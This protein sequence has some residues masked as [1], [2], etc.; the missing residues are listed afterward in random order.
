MKKILL[1]FL[2]ILTNGLFGEGFS[3]GTLVC[4]TDKPVFVEELK[5]GDEL[6]C[7]DF[8]TGFS[9]D[10]IKNIFKSLEEKVVCIK[11]GEEEVACSAK[12]RFLD[13]ELFEWVR[14][15]DLTSQNCLLTVD[16]KVCAVRSVEPVSKKLELFKISMERHPNFFV[17]QQGFLAHNMGAQQVVGMMLPSSAAVPIGG[18]AGALLGKRAAAQPN[19]FEELASQMSK[20]HEERQKQ[21]NSNSSQ[22]PDSTSSQPPQKKPDDD[23]KKIGEFQKAKYHHQNSKG[24][25]SPGPNNEDGQKWLDKSKK[26]KNKKFDR[27]YKDKPDEYKI[28]K[29][30]GRNNATKDDIYHGFNKTRRQLD[31][32]E[33][34]TAIRENW[35]TPKGKD[36]R[37]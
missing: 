22:K 23:K 31:T 29:K 37:K 20:K 28:F 9:I 10:K 21:K 15:E 19:C 18:V 16:N 24:R 5:T 33:R 32:N 25:K 36:I 6:V 17:C 1:L 34:A 35:M 14:A 11:A 26:V 4:T 2:L 27:A 30:T 3:A 12:Q 13:H 8:Q 7:F